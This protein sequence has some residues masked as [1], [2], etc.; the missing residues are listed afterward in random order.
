MR[1]KINK[2]PWNLVLGYTK[3]LIS[4]GLSIGCDHLI[5]KVL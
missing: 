3:K 1:V 5:F 4:Y 2:C